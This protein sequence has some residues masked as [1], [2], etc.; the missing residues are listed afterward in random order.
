MVG[1]GEEASERGRWKDRRKV[2]IKVEWTKQRRLCLEWTDQTAQTFPA[3]GACC[4]VQLSRHALPCQALPAGTVRNRFSPLTACAQAE[5]DNPLLLSVTVPT[6][7]GGPKLLSLSDDRGVPQQVLRNRF[8]F[9]HDFFLKQ[10]NKTQWDCGNASTQKLRK[11]TFQDYS[12]ILINTSFLFCSHEVD[13]KSGLC[14][15]SAL[16]HA[17]FCWK[18][19]IGNFRMSEDILKEIKCWTEEL[20]SSPVSA[21]EFLSGANQVT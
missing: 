2:S 10:H 3:S 15:I 17:K 19:R 11:A 12:S 4:S 6:W 14:G 9:P 7:H 18:K 5:E 16:F 13:K 1:W 21:T 20:A 8:F